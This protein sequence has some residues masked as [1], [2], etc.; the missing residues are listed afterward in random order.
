MQRLVPRLVPSFLQTAANLTYQNRPYQFLLPE[1][2]VLP[3]RHLRASNLLSIWTRKQMIWHNFPWIHSF[4][5]LFCILSFSLKRDFYFLLK[6]RFE[7]K[8]FVY[9]SVLSKYADK[10]FTKSIKKS[11]IIYQETWESSDN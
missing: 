10:I 11:R 2:F 5:V 1:K 4:Y 7:I 9:F 6:L 3:I 8:L